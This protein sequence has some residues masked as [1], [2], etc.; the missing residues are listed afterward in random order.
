MRLELLY[1]NSLCLLQG[2]E[3]FEVAVSA[4]DEEGRRA[5]ISQ[6]EDR[7]EQSHIRFKG[8]RKSVLTLYNPETKSFRQVRSLLLSLAAPMEIGPSGVGCFMLDLIQ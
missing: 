5:L 2:R 7:E 3:Q 1:I 4:P 6:I 8:F